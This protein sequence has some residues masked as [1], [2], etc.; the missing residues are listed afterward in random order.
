[1]KVVAL[2]SGG[3][4]STVL[5]HYLKK[6]GHEVVA[7]S[8]DYGQ[9]HKKEISYA[10]KNCDEL[11][12]NRYVC[13]VQLPISVP[14][15]GEGKIPNGYYTDES[16][17]KT[18]VPSRNAIF[19]SIAWGVALNL[20]VNAVSFAAHGGDHPIYPDCRPDFV[21]AMEFALRLGSDSLMRIYTPFID[22]DKTG[23]V[24]VGDTLGVAFSSTWSC[25]K[26]DEVHCGKCGT[27]SERIEAFQLSGVPDPTTY[28]EKL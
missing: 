1:M 3:L 8:F 18:I 17:K 19:L 14:L 21:D 28:K 26:G 25:Y 5:L 11:G 15:M 12:V 27:C 24:K 10:K 2:Y 6:E 13:K 20:D 23:I 22:T 16:M 4:D 7:L 9:M